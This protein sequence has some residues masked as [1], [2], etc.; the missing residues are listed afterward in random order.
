MAYI[1][2]VERSRGETLLEPWV[3]EMGWHLLHMWRDGLSIRA[4]MFH[5]GGK[6]IYGN[7]MLMS[8]PDIED[9]WKFSSDCSKC[10]IKKERRSSARTEHWG[11]SVRILKRKVWNSHLG[12]WVN[13][14]P[15]KARLF[16]NVKCKVIPLMW[17]CFLCFATALYSETSGKK[18]KLGFN[19]SFIKPATMKPKKGK[20]VKEIYK[21]VIS[22]ACGIQV[23][24]EENDD[25]VG[26]KDIEMLLGSMDWRSWQERKAVHFDLKI[27]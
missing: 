11:R 25:I 18:Q 5:S 23:I 9:L 24:K 20:T 21:W 15:R 16:S 10:L 3:G 7:T 14:P 12:M 17:L 4:W 6:A 27:P 22:I 19:H 2:D 1:F 26:M 8:R 13:R